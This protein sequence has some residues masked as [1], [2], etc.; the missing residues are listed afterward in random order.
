MSSVIRF[1]PSADR[2]VESAFVWYEVNAGLAWV[3]NFSK[4]STRRS[5]ASWKILEHIKSSAA[6]SEEFFCAGNSATVSLPV[7]YSTYDA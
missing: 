2:D 3:M 5:L 6:E 7:P 1:K 4:R